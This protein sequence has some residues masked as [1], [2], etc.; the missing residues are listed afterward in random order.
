MY[1]YLFGKIRHKTYI[2]C[3]GIAMYTLIKSCYKLF[4]KGS[5]IN[6]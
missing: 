5:Y 4:S 2:T 3:C 1:I 6:F